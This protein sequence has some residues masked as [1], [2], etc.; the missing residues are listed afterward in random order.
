MTAARRNGQV[1]AVKAALAWAAIIAW[2]ALITTFSGEGFSDASTSRFIDPLARWLFPDVSPTTLAAIH[3]VVRKTAHTVEYG[4]LALLALLALRR[5]FRLSLRAS[6]VLALAIVTV[7]GTA[8]EANQ[9]RLAARSGTPWDV[10]LD[11]AGG[12][13][14]LAILFSWRRRAGGSLAPPATSSR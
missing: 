7:V 3:F 4:V 6:T 13:L 9:A 1:N 10:M 12:V 2:I 11:L 5:S 8:D 14:A